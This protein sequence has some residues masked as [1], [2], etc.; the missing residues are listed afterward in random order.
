MIRTGRRLAYFCNPIEPGRDCELKKAEVFVDWRTDSETDVEA[1]MYAMVQWLDAECTC[2]GASIGL[3]CED[4]YFGVAATDGLFPGL[5]GAFATVYTYSQIL[6]QDPV[7]ETWL[8]LGRR[9]DDLG[10]HLLIKH[11]PIRGRPRRISSLSHFQRQRFIS[12]LTFENDIVDTHTY[13]Q[14]SKY[15]QT[16]WRLSISVRSRRTTTSNEGGCN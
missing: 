14:P 3:L 13:S 16:Y 5:S 4:V 10:P 8:M 11:R 12:S 7:E 15:Q 6:A 1:S 9:E 2:Q